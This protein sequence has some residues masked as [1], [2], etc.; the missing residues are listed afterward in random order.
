VLMV[1]FRDARIA[2]G[3]FMRTRLSHALSHAVNEAWVES[4]G[5]CSSRD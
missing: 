1:L 4:A 2:S 3:C 5:T